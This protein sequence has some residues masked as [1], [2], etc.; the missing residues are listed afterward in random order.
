M[1]EDRAR[2]AEVAVVTGAASG[3]GRAIAVRLA[4]DGYRTVAIDIDEGGLDRLRSEVPDA[5][6]ERADVG[7]EAE[8]GALAA[9]V[10]H[11]L[12]GASVLVNSAGLLQSSASLE[13]LDLDEH[14]RIWRVNYRGTF[15]ACRVFGLAMARSGGGAIVNVASITGL[16]P[17]PLIAYGPGKA[18]VISLT[19]SLAGHLGPCGVRVNA[20]AP[21]YVLTPAM[22]AR[23]QAGERDVSAL[24]KPAALGRLVRPEEVA[25]AVAF[26]VGP[27]A[28]AITGVTLPVDAGWLAGSSWETYG[29]LRRQPTKEG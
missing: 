22:N 17:L 7:S 28:T 25:D 14:D 19:E 16:R 5:I 9:K 8:V 13:A 29:G 18:A 23:I 1:S 15:L 21:G 6:C 11:E 12:G 26:L 10:E 3:I 4:G 27:G 24:T 2:A 20:V